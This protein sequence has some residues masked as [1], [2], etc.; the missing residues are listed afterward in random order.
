MYSESDLDAAIAAGALSPEAVDKFRAYMAAQKTAPAVDEEY[1]R[2][3]TGFNDIFV[4]TA[5]VLV[6]IATGVLTFSSGFSGL[7]VAAESWG[8]AEYF[9]R[10]RRMALPSILLLLTY[11]GGCALAVEQAIQAIN[12]PPISLFHGAEN[13]VLL[14]YLAIGAAIIAG[15]TYVHWRRFHVPITVAA[16]IGMVIFFALAALLTVFPALRQNWPLPV[17]LC[18]AAVFALAL[19]WDMTDLARTTRRSDVAFWLHLLAAP[20]LV[21]P[22]FQSL[23]LLHDNNPGMAHALLAVLAYAVLALVALLVDRRALLVSG[24]AYVL[25][26]LTAMLKASGIVGPDL[27]LTALVAGSALLLLSAFWHKTR[28]GVLALMPAGIR[29]A[30]PSV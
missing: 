2:L 14:A 19:R 6:I 28:E 5:I 12:G 15:A 26:A 8:L 22:V 20:L 4:S 25:S 29:G 16:G 10:R 11:T 27:A 30:L 21:H 3:L 18:G 13:P 17:F 24:L 9:T 23:G 1:V 7:F